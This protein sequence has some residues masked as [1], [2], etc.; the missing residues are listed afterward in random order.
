VQ[1]SDPPTDMQVPV[2]K[3]A[4]QHL[5]FPPSSRIPLGAGLIIAITGVSSI[6]I[7]QVLGGFRG[8]TSWLVGLLPGVFT[9]M[10]HAV[11]GQATYR[12][13]SM[14]PISIWVCGLAWAVL[15]VWI[16]VAAK[17]RIAPIAVSAMALITLLI[18]VPSIEELIF[19]GL[20]NANDARNALLLL[21]IVFSLFVVLALGLLVALQR[22]DNAASAK[23]V[24]TTAVTLLAMSAIYSFVIGVINS[25][26]FLPAPG[27]DTGTV[28]FRYIFGLTVIV[29][30][31]FPYALIKGGL[32]ML[33]AGSVVRPSGIVQLDDLTRTEEW[34]IDNVP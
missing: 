23:V 27:E 28:Q 18:I 8:G 14:Y 16:I 13:V 4:S 20:T 29:L 6:F 32:L 24:K 1:H 34:P 17:R 22:V 15:G 5:Q 26:K 11:D 25:V 30:S 21:G 3:P 10:N 19:A 31:C 7:I 9:A 2:K 12:F 33:A